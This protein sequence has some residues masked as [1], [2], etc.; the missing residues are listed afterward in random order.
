MY[1]G[2]F[3]RKQRTAAC[4]PPGFILTWAKGPRIATLNMDGTGELVGEA[5]KLCGSSLPL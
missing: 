4:P 2:D 1:P 5:E 3:P